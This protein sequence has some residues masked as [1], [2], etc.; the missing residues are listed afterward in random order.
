MMMIER[1]APKKLLWRP[2]HKPVPEAGAFLRQPGQQTFLRNLS[3]N[4]KRKL[5][6]QTD[7]RN[8]TAI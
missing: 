2:G 4:S 1:V 3:S 5:E 6:A 7:G 8:A